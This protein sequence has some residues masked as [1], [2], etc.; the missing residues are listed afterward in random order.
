VEW[1]LNLQNR[2]GG[3]PTFC[4]GWG[5]LPFDQSSADLTAHAMRAWSAWLP[6]L[7]MEQQRQVRKAMV[8]ASRYLADDQEQGSDRAGG[9][10]PLWFGD[11]HGED[12]INWTYGTSRVLLALSTDAP[13]NE[14]E[15]RTRA[16]AQWLVATQRADGGWGGGH[17]GGASSVEETALAVEALAGLL[18]GQSRGARRE[19]APKIESAMGRGV[20]WLVERVE[21]GS[22]TKPAP[23]GFYFAKL[24]YFERLYPMIF[25]V[26]ALGRAARVMP[27]QGVE[28][29]NF[30]RLCIS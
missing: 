13:K 30:D 3:V 10:K 27:A 21:D 11:Q 25:T 14:V 12:E 4:R 17:G 15:M 28:G 6:D 26:G 5:K 7:S 8:R 18:E 23:I 20:L 29:V 24:W 1:L 16:A 22:W 2:D 9:W 19:L